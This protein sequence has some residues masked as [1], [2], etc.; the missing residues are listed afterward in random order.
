MAQR[1]LRLCSH[2][3]IQEG[4]HT[5]FLRSSTLEMI[6]RN[7]QTTGATTDVVRRAA[8]SRAWLSQELTLST[9]SDVD[10]SITTALVTSPLPAPSVCIQTMK[11]N[12]DG[13]LSRTWLWTSMLQRITYILKKKQTEMAS[14]LCQWFPNDNKSWIYIYSWSYFI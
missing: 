6:R 10:T 5:L 4:A 11:I 8:L 9:F 7:S 13:A 14:K 12:L 1:A 2:R 3:H